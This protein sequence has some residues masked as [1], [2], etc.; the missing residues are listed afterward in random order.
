[1]V[2]CT[3]NPGQLLLS[4]FASFEINVFAFWRNIKINNVYIKISQTNEMF[5]HNVYSK[6]M[7][8]RVCAYFC[9]MDLC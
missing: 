2:T 1:M 3:F 6:W 4:S 9:Y 8:V 5:I 7:N